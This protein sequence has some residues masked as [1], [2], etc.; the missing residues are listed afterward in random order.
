MSS[1]LVFKF[2]AVLA[3]L[4]C[5][6]VFALPAPPEKRAGLKIL[7]GNDDGWFEA[8]FRA[9][10][11]KLKQDGHTVA[12]SAPVQ[13]QSGRGSLELPALPLLFEEG[14]YGSVPKGS[15]AQGADPQ[16][17][18]IF[19]VNSTPVTAIKFGLSDVCPK[20]FGGKPDLVVS[21]PNAGNNLGIVTPFS[22]TVGVATEAVKQGFPAIA[23]SADSDALSFKNS[24]PGDNAHVYADLASKVT[25][26]VIA[27]RNG[28]GFLPPGVSLNV[29]F[30]KPSAACPT[31]DK[32]KFVLTKIYSEI[33][34]L[35]NLIGDALPQVCLLGK[36]SLKGVCGKDKLPSENSVFGK[37][38]VVTISVMTKDK[39]DGSVAQQQDVLN[40]LK[41]KAQGG[42]LDCA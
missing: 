20:I 22:G 40:R 28:Q 6:N 39:C 23:F 10:N 29:N 14:Q 19:Y 27:S 16:D 38:C 24:G 1:S 15:P 30:A 13:N 26:A 12:G 35:T 34:D 11:Q 31:A 25:K 36:D 2:V 3:A 42:L 9:F 5:S 21:G 37:G 17:R 4:G 32:Y 18:S 33:L 7:M 8:N 41:L